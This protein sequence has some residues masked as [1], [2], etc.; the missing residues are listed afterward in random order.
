M[1]QYKTNRF[2]LYHTRLSKASLRDAPPRVLC[3][4]N[5]RARTR[6]M[7]ASSRTLDELYDARK[8]MELEMGTI[9]AR[10]SAPGAPGLK[11]S[12]VDRE[13]FPIAGCDLYAVRSDRQRY[14]STCA[15]RRSAERVLFV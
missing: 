3:H 12:L 10:L 15:R 1:L 11:G 5:P 2:I 14:N 7:N 13:G 9:S 4:A 6:D 8:L